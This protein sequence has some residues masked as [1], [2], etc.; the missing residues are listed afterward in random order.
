MPT[1]LMDP[2][3]VLLL[4]A[5]VSVLMALVH[6]GIR[7]SYPASVRV[8]REWSG[9]MMTFVGGCLLAASGD[10]LPPILSVAGANVGLLLGVYLAYVGTQRFFG[11][12]PNLLAW[13]SV[14]VVASLVCGWF[15]W[16]EPNYALR[17]RATTL[18]IGAICAAHAWL[19][20]RQGLGSFA[21]RAAF[22]TLLFSV[23][24]Q[25]VRAGFTLE[26]TPLTSVLDKAVYHQVYLG[27]CILGLLLTTLSAMLMASERMA[28]EL[29]ERAAHD[30][31]TGLLNRRYMDELCQA[32]LDRARRKGRCV[33]LLMI[34]LDHF[35]RINDTHGHLAGDEVL[36]A[37]AQST[38]QMLRPSD[39]LGR[40]GGEEFVAMLPET[41]QSQAVLVA[42]RIRSSCSLSQLKISHTVSIGLATT[43]SVKDSLR[44]MLKRA[45]EALYRAKSLGRNRVEV[46]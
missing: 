10:R 35:K 37:F 23:G 33:A 38:R 34:D 41:D 9:S 24:N 28:E 1:T 6:H 21:K 42:E 18:V 27:A 3:T 2:R 15:T 17:L 22:F 30:H 14:L 45:D 31:L 7:R 39:A 36:V 20:Y 29:R 32:E 25:L 26:Q 46:G 16:M 13:A 44:D 11:V 40:F 4:T 5:F 19:V 12:K 8:P 43:T